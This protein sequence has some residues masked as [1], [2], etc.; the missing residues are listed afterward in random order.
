MVTIRYKAGKWLLNSF[1]QKCASAWLFKL[2]A[3]F[4][5]FIILFN[6]QC[7][8]QGTWTTLTNTAPHY[9][10]GE[11]IL[12][13]DGTVLC[14]TS[15]GGTG[16]GNTW[17]KLTP[18]SHGSYI[19]GT[20]STIDTMHDERLYFSTQVLNDGRL[21]VAGGEYG[22][23]GDKGEVYNPVTN[24][25]TAVPQIVFSLSS[26]ISDAN[27]ELLA[28]GK[29]LQAVVDTGGTVLNY[30]WD[31]GTNTYTQT[32]S[33]RG[34]DNEAMWVKLPDYSILFIDNYGTTSE[35][36]IPASGTWINDGTVPV[37]LY[38]PYGEEAGAAF[39]L[40]N[41][42]AFFIGSKP[43]TAY[44][45]P[46]GTNSP[47][48]WTAGPA[49]PSNQGAP[50]AA[51]AM[52][53][54]GKILMAVSPTPSTT[55]H[56]P[57]SIAYYEFNY[58]T[59]TFTLVSSP[60]GG[61]LLAGAAY[62]LTNM[63]CLPDGSILYG[64]QGD[65]QYY[66]YVPGGT[67]V[68]AGVPTVTNVLRVNCDTFTAIGTLFNGISE[69]A[70]YGDDWQMSTNY[71]II[72]LTSGTNVYYAKSYGWNRIGAVQT[73]SAADTT[74][75][76]LP[77]GL[78]SGTY[79]LQVIA[80]GIPSVN[81]NFSTSL[82][83][84]PPSAAICQLGTI[85]VTDTATGGVW[86][87]SN[88]AIA[89]IGSV[90]GVVTG[91][92][93][94]V[95][96]I[97]YSIGECFSVAKVTVNTTPA[98]IS[99]AAASICN[100]ATAALTDGTPLGTWGTQNA[101]IATVTS[102]TV[103]ATSTGTVNISYTI[104]S[105]SAIA[106]VTVNP[107]P[108]ATI[109]PSGL[110]TFCAGGSVALNANT[111]AG[112][113][114]QWQNGAGIISGATGSSY[115]ALSTDNYEVVVS[116]ASGCSATSVVTPVTVN[117]VPAATITPAGITSFCAGG[118]VMLNANTGA[119]LTYQWQNGAGNIIGSTT[120][121][122]T[123]ATTDNYKVVVTNSFGCIATS[124]VT[125][126][127][128]N[129]LP[130]ATIT[131]AGSTN[132]CAGSNVTLNANAGAG[133]TYQWQNGAGVIGGS[134]GSSYI[135]S[136]TDNYKVAVTNS[137][138][139]SATSP[140]TTVTVNPVPTATIT[141][142]GATTFCAGGNVLLN[143]NTGAGLTYQW[144]NG[145]GNIAGATGSSY[146][147]A[148]SDNYKVVVT[149][150][151]ACNATSAATGVTVN[152]SPAATIT[153][154]GPTTFCAGGNVTLNAT[155]GAGLTYQ[156]Q[157]GAGSIGG[158]T[159]ASY[160]ASAAD[161]YKVL[162]TNS[163]SCNTTSSA[164]TVNVNPLPTATITPAGPTT[165]CNGGSVVLNA[166]TGAGLTYQWQNGAGNISGAT[167]S[168]YT[169]SL[170]DN[171]VVVVTNS[172]GCNTT[173]TATTV[174]V[175]L[176]AAATVTPGGPLTFCAGGNVMLNA[177]SGTGLAYQ[178]LNSSGIIAGA[179]GSSYTASSAG[180]YQLIVSNSFSCIDTSAATVVVVD[181]VPAATIT[182]AGATTFCAG[183]N[184]LLNANTGAG[185]TYQWQNAA[186]IISGAVSASYTA[187]SSDSYT[188]VVGNSFGCNTTSSVTPVVV[189]PVP[190]AVITPA[191][192]TTFCAGGSVTLNATAGAGFSYQWLDGAGIIGGA[193]NSFY[194]ANT[195]DNY[196]VVVTNSFGCFATS[197]ATSVL[198][199]PLP[200]ATI[201][202]AGPTTFCAGGSVVL[203][204]NIGA[205]L[206]YQWQNTAGA[207]SGAISSS[208]T[209]SAAS[210]Y[211]VVVTDASGCVATSAI[212]NV[213][214]NALPTVSISPVGATTFCA[215]GSV[216]LDATIGAG[217]TYQWEV[218]G[219]PISGA[220]TVSYTASASGTYKALVVN[221]AGCNGSSSPISVTV[222]SM[223]SA[224]LGADSVCIGSTTNLSDDSTGGT[225]IS[226]NPLI[227]PV[228]SGGVVSG[229][230]SVGTAVITYDLS[231]CTVT[232]MVTVNT[233]AVAPI[234]G[235]S[236]I[237]C[238][239]A[240]TLLTDAASGGTWSSSVSSVAPVGSTGSVTGAALGAAVISYSITNG[241][242]TAIATYPITI[243]PGGAGGTISGALSVCL[244][245]TS[246]LSDAAPFG[247]WSSSNGAVSTIS[248]TGGASGV[249][250]GTDTISYTVVS[251]SGCISVATAAFTVFSPLSAT[252]TPGGSTS[253]CTGG[254]VLLN[255]M[256]GSGMSYQWENGGVNIAGATSS[257][258]TANTSGSYTVFITLP[259]GCHSTSL[260][261]TVS[262]NPA[263]I[264]VPG[265]SIATHPGTSL[266]VGATA[267]TFTATAVNGGVPVYNWFV[268]GIA[269][270]TGATYSYSSSAGDIVKVVLTSSAACAFPTTADTSETIA[271]NPVQTPSVSVSV[272]PSP[273]ACIGDTI[274][275][276]A[277]PVY[278]GSFPAFHWTKNG[279]SA[280]SGASY[281]YSFAD[282][283]V[284][285]C[286]MISDYPC[287]STDSATS[288]PVTVHVD[289]MVSN[290]VTISVSDSDFVPGRLDSFVA[291]APNGGTSPAYQWLLNGSPIPGATAALYITS[292]L[293]NGE[294]FSCEVTSDKPCALPLTQ[295]SN[296]IKVMMK[297][298]GIRQ[299]IN[300][301]GSFTILPNPN[302]GTFTI[303]G[304]LA[305]TADDNVTIVITDMLGQ[306]VYTH[307]AIATN[308]QLNDRIVLDN[309]IA[310]GMY[311]VSITS[312]QEH[313]VFHVVVDK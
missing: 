196:K 266:C 262:V 8:A 144:Q 252:I 114:Y 73:G 100:G 77:A 208:Y 9:N 312:G 172:F 240:S 108:T 254:Y 244:G 303:S 86:S 63:L 75:F 68:V 200:A 276:T 42:Q 194:T 264:V 98:A 187:S 175:N 235:T 117:P 43:I 21:Y 296:G 11:L 245:G 297:T 284:L 132:L 48:T 76:I 223:P 268:N 35:R 267:D 61:T 83:I 302:K 261:V 190:L 7:Y 251:A 29:V 210:G 47:G 247:V 281:T 37:S 275:A 214:V 106:V 298:S 162:V 112:L 248:A 82:G 131:P 151:F 65:D 278:G 96:T 259:A 176:T 300:H 158:A 180:N 149:N 182:P 234:S 221:P 220:T 34:V 139:C 258:Y 177:P 111:G 288:A 118:N 10:E 211:S 260:P 271:V 152:P 307:T 201:T 184:V 257:G 56:F 130:A 253:F 304:L 125:P 57:D 141:P 156:W 15:S 277:I 128:V 183:A 167:G 250:Y 231:G 195:T 45:T 212:T 205:G 154:A 166:N 51:A 273:V 134:T 313:A 239:G 159:S 137:F 140:V 280:A 153:P 189:N 157:N 85:T 170:A 53:P 310:N 109:T 110:T 115:T 30:I 287:V 36:Y 229:T 136:A 133:L 74:K 274:V 92:A 216:L 171:Y 188:V 202:P 311:L 1:F 217:Y 226:S 138:G 192:A 39:M 218:G 285:V 270:A 25:W 72:R 283:D 209:A 13:T 27:S 32:G 164:T 203:N 69:G 81:Y 55:D 219:V 16:Y 147:A 290:T 22:S 301:E 291:I 309:A 95:A 263:P 121:S 165:F 204:A 122:Y 38:D 44:Y 58:T 52:M 2:P 62:Y 31:P 236:G 14:K 255:T 305:N 99:P 241:C 160:I 163:F 249:G 186:G 146:T 148:L 124:A 40:P 295:L 19:N 18:D 113:T 282:G 71:P 213:I 243:S 232:A 120:S 289:P 93:T 227:A 103:T 66:D 193:V 119:G 5:V 105:C 308:G 123:A 129:A 168:A 145:A 228:S 3:L 80:N 84:A 64:T 197:A 222:H 173:S 50:D 101:A 207:I 242:G 94:G 169:A 174:I 54:N 230:G 79:A 135:A 33:C 179:T 59:N 142:A 237:L 292:A 107:Q 12:L 23:G 279:V 191:G 46:T 185:L 286:T 215:G 28:N 178:W 143:A 87:S 225:W 104:G 6:S 4:V 91:A 26:K 299:V 24:T 198:V 306:V 20:W 256:S 199:N 127:T 70:G 246:L 150:S 272:H 161:N 155:A 181:P 49:I 102:G 206:T 293:T 224:I 126:V 41:G 265:V 269:A 233:V 116:N 89:A 60:Y 90:S 78:P 17:D 97:S 238:I 67:P 294:V 88:S